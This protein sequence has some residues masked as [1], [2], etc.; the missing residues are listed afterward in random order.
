VIRNT[1]C[2]LYVFLNVAQLRLWLQGV[3]SWRRGPWPQQHTNHNLEHPSGKAQGTLTP[4]PDSTL[5]P[6]TSTVH[7]PSPQAPPP[8][9]WHQGTS[10][11]VPSHQSTSLGPQAHPAGI[12]TR[13]PGHWHQGTRS[14]GH[15]GTQI[16]IPHGLQCLRVQW[17]W[18]HQHTPEHRPRAS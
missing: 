17:F 11:S 6:A 9:H 12:C 1:H 7:Q 10:A 8:R 14:P 18:G 13:A 4:R 2:F 5:T 16:P 15:Q 3:V